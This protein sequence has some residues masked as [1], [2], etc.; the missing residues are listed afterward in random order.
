[1]E[2]P[3]IIM[4]SYRGEPDLQSLVDLFDACEQVDQLESSTSIAQLRQ[5]LE[6]PSLDRNRDL[7]LWKNDQGQLMGFG[8]VWVMEPTEDDLADGWIKFIV[9]PNARRG[10][11]AQQI[12]TWAE[13][14]MSEVGRERHGQPK[15]MASIRNSR[16]DRIAILKDRGFVENRH[17]LCLSRSLTETIPQP[18]L[19]KGFAIRSVN[20]SMEAQIWVELHNRCFSGHW[21]YHPMTLEDSLDRLQHPNY[22]PELDLV[23]IDPDGRFASACHCSIDPAHNTFTGRQEGW[24]ISLFTNP[25]FQRRGLAR[26]ML[27]H[28]LA[29]L[30][31]LKIDIAKINVDSEN[32]FGAKNLYQSVGFE[33]LYTNIAY[34]KHL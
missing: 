28:G 2:S 33:H 11:L 10:D 31:A 19:P 17:L 12:I 24:I 14:R 27:F 23:A 5:S 22:S 26:A 32:A 13:E 9:H 7:R 34:V 6:A 18:P 15:L 1:M 16:A 4:R 21:N 3:S 20:R 29:R 8:Q 30:Q 25:E